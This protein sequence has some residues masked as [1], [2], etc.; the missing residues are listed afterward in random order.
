[1]REG[2][3]YGSPD[4][5][6]NAEYG[7]GYRPPRKR[8]GLT[9]LTHLAAAVL[10]AGVAVGV[11]L[12]VGRPASGTARPAPSPALP[13]AGAVPNPAASSPAGA[14]AGVQQVVNKVEPGLVVISTT[15]AYN[16]EAAAGTGMI[17]NRDGLVL[18]NN[19]VIAGATKITATAV[20]TGTTYPATVVGYDKSGDIALLR[21]Q[22]V[23]GLQ[24]VPLGDSA[25]VK[26]GTPVV[27]LGNAEGQGTM[28]P[29]GGKVSALGQ[30]IT[31]SDQGSTASTETLHGMIQT[32]AHIVPGDSGGPLS[33]ASGQVIAMDTAGNS[34]STTQQQ[35]A[36]GFAIPIDTA[37]AVARQI[38]AGHAS[39]AVTIG[40]PPFLGIFTASGTS[41]D[42]QVQAEQQEQSGGFGDGF[43]GFGGF[44]SGSLAPA[45]PACYT[46]NSS[47][48]VPSQIAPASSGSLVDGTICGSPAATAG[49]TG[50]SVITAIDGQPAGSP[51]Q[52]TSLLARYRPGETIA[53]T[54]I[55]P[56]GQRTTSNIR[57]TGGP[58]Q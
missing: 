11:T 23:S 49:I 45:A 47:L 52:L 13:G 46:S 3:A 16:S 36:A 39:T 6:S 28:I 27:A 42:P 7:S 48:T 30:T 26:P 33:T 9:V 22:G 54:W 14:T 31:A 50:G 43:G 29:A 25:A 40:Y 18:T 38:A 10:A 1:M 24:T 41:P 17:I 21:L 57:L 15:Q 34:V 5:G 32:S 44:G 20:A 35:S 55:S 2:S 53:V 37:L 56:S 8:R 58:P 4:S 51:A 12:G 19:H